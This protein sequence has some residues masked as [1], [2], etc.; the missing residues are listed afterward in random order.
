MPTP[1]PHG[2][3]RDAAEQV[4]KRMMARKTIN[5]DVMK[6]I[7]LPLAVMLSAFFVLTSCLGDDAYE[8]EYPRD[9]A[10]TAFSLGNFNRYQTV[11]SST[12]ADSTVKSVING[13]SYKFYIDQVRR[14][15]YNPDSLPYGTDV[16]HMMCTVLSKNAGTIVIKNVNSDTL[17]YYNS[18]D[19]INFSVPRVFSV[20]SLDGTNRVDYTVTVNVNKREK[21]NLTWSK[22]DTIPDFASAQGMKAVACGDSVYVFASYGTTGAIFASG[23]NGDM[24]WDILQWNL[25]FPIPADAYKNI[26]VQGDRMFLYANGAILRSTNGIDW[27]YTGAA[28]L[29]Q[30]VAASSTRLYAL[31]E[32]MKLISTTDEGRTWNNEQLDDDMAFLPVRDISYCCIPSIMDDDIE[33]VVLIGNRD[34]NAYPADI[35]AQVWSKVEDNSDTPFA[36][37]WMHVNPF[38]RYEMALP[39]LTSLSTFVYNGGIVA[40][41]GSGIGACNVERFSHFYHANDGGIYWGDPFFIYLPKSFNS[42]DVFTMTVDRNNYLWMICG[43]TG[44]VWHSRLME[45]SSYQTVFTE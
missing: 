38:D 18:N 2:W 31:D 28:E 43:G 11:V 15:I 35:Q 21:N 39:R 4:N 34:V 26:V 14:T 44:Q 29:S 36:H 6:R 7:F 40:L 45:N 12:G 41:G 13:N 37:S 10:I 20:Y 27:D 33:H 9:A 42:S 22:P 24:R 17:N 3:M 1:F 25:N 23:I 8:I 32:G 19:S 5:N 16:A 30:L